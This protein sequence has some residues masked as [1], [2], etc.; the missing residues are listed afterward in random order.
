MCRE[1]LTNYT[2][3]PRNE[4]TEYYISDDPEL[5]AQIPAALPL[6]ARQRHPAA[7]LLHLPHVRVQGV[8]LYRCHRL[9]ERE[10]YSAEDRP[11]PVC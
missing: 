11:Q 6:G 4:Q 2:L 5:N 10:D 7:A 1:P 3:S 9:P 8:Q